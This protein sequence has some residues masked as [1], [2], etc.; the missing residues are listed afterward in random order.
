M[1]TLNTFDQ[2]LVSRF[3]PIIKCVFQSFFICSSNATPAFF[4]F[5][6]T[7]FILQW[8][9]LPTSLSSHSLKSANKIF[10]SFYPIANGCFLL[11][12]C[13]QGLLDVREPRLVRFFV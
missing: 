12:C 1:S 6:P 11:L 4:A 5:L 9:G 3:S 8:G 7:V 2:A 13:C 10:S